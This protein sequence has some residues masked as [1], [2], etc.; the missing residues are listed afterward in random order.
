MNQKDFDEIMTVLGGELRTCDEMT[1]QAGLLVAVNSLMSHAR[2]HY[3]EV[4]PKKMLA[5]YARGLAPVLQA[6]G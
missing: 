3:P 1:E 5:A 6:T 4:D 2:H